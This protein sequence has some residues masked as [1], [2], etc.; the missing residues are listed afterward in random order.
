MWV[1]VSPSWQT[2]GVLWRAGQAGATSQWDVSWGRGSETAPCLP[3]LCSFSNS[4]F[5]FSIFH[6]LKWKIELIGG[7]TACL[8]S[9]VKLASLPDK[10]PT[11]NWR[12]CTLPQFNFPAAL[13]ATD[14]HTAAGALSLFELAHFCTHFDMETTVTLISAGLV[15][16]LLWLFLQ[17]S[18]KQHRLPPGPSA[19]PIIGNLLELDKR[20]PFKSLLKVRM[21]DHFHFCNFVMQPV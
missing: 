2:I 9:N 1:G 11:W 4:V 7:R 12:H 17:K 13:T 18:R 16:V 21:W 3:T 5:R 10:H 8:T 20:A 15:L 6:P 19:L 14:Y